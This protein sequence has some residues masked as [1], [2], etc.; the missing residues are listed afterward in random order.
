MR[1]STSNFESPATPPGPQFFPE[2]G[3]ARQIRHVWTVIIVL[4]TGLA[5]ILLASELGA[6]YLYPRISQIEHRVV[7]DQREVMSLAG[8]HP[9]A[10]PTV[11]VVGNSL[12]LH[13][14]DYPK[15]QK[16]MGANVRVVRYGIENTEYLDWYYGLRSLFARGVRPDL[17]V[18]CLNV[19]QTLS[20]SV[21]DESAFRLFRARDL[22]AVSRAAKMSNTEASGLVFDHL[23]AFYASR[24]GVRNYILN[25]TQRSYAAQL[26]ILARHPPVYPPEEKMIED[27]R[28]RL[29]A[30]NQLCRE[31]G[32][33][34]LLVIPPALGNRNEVLVKAGALE[35]VAVDA[36]G[37]I[38][39]LGPE[40]FLADRFHV[41]AKGAELFTEG[42]TR[43]L[44]ARFGPH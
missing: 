40:Y 34:F 30:L 2:R 17:V 38:D 10:D 42:L 39:Q 24:S 22:W 36:P 3:D 25:V 9:G 1:S 35:G 31:N 7:A 29:R 21:L 12:L 41:N 18:L 43:D 4:L 15:I 5:L 26:H 44:Q 32:V 19:G 16:E 8:Q 28:V 14:L 20:H 13:G 37:G 6:R 33:G 23:S 27:S 11:L